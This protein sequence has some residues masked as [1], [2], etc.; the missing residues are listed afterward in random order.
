MGRSRAE[1]LVPHQAN[2]SRSRGRFLISITAAGEGCIGP[3]EAL[4][5]LAVYMDHQD[6]GLHNPL[7]EYPDRHNHCSGM[8]TTRQFVPGVRVNCNGVRG[9]RFLTPSSH[10]FTG[11]YIGDTLQKSDWS[12]GRTQH[13][14][15]VPPFAPVRSQ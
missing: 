13:D 6:R 5:K 3:I 2:S 9:V 8:A 1:A 11:L 12:P 10:F 15:R 14:P 7:A 4:Q